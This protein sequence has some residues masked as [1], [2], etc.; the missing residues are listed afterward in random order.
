[1]ALS[2]TTQEAMW[3]RGF[4]R[5]LHGTNGALVIHCDNKSAINLA[6]REVGYSVRSKHIDIR[7]HYVREQVE[8]K[9]IK[10]VYV[11]SELQAADILTKALPGPKHTEDRKKLG[12]YNFTLK[13]GC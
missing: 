9:T 11:A 5:E 7:H 8:D 6:E 4:L 10:L 3:W 2:T 13:G 1:M 12:F